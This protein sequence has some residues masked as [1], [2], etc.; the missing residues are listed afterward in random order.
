MRYVAEDVI[1][2]HL[3]LPLPQHR[4][5]LPDLLQPYS[6]YLLRNNRPVLFHLLRRGGLGTDV[7]PPLLL[8]I[9][10]LQ[11]QGLAGSHPKAGSCTHAKGTGRHLSVETRVGA[12]GH[13]FVEGIWGMGVLDRCLGKLTKQ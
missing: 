4:P 7:I 2:R 5:V 6:L 11:K 12:L 10:A 3:L 13:P 8:P 9:N 1:L